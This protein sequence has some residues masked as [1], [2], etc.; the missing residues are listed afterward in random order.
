MASDKKYQEKID[1][2]FDLVED[3]TAKLK[4][5]ENENKE[6]KNQ[7]ETLKANLQLPDV[8]QLQ[9]HINHTIENKIKEL[10]L[11]VTQK[12]NKVTEQKIETIN[13]E[14]DEMNAKFEN[15]KMIIKSSISSHKKLLEEKMDTLTLSVE[16]ANNEINQLM[17]TNTSK[18]DKLKRHEDIQKELREKLTLLEEN[19]DQQ[20]VEN[21]NNL[22]TELL[23]IVSNENNKATQ[24]KTANNKQNARN[25]ESANSDENN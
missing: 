21:I 15:H 20:L 25:N 16:K 13:A 17:C 11:N 22:R 5:L 14:K 9:N 8:Q 6:Q 2:L 4:S 24:P 10:Q 7:V 18:S 23:K 1:I 12:L 19:T 3:L